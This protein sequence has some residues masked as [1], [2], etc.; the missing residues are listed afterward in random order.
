MFKY[1]KLRVVKSQKGSPFSLGAKGESS[2]FRVDLNKF[3]FIDT[4]NDKYSRKNMNKFFW[5]L[6]GFGG[7]AEIR[8]EILEGNN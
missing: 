2:D 3:F 4:K 8:L 5:C 6:E 7:N 1:Q